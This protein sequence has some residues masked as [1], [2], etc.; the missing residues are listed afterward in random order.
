MATAGR[1]GTVKVW[2]CRNWKGAVR[3]WTTRGGGN[4]ELDWSARGYLSV[5]SGGTVNVDCLALSQ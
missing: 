3:D 5:A 1:D 2:D 4:P